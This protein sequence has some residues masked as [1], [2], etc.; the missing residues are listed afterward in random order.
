ML[1]TLE[2]GQVGLGFGG[3][4]GLQLFW[5]QADLLRQLSYG[6]GGLCSGDLDVTVGNI[7][8]QTLIR[9]VVHNVSHNVHVNK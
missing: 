9:E 8:K 5:K 1:K 7:K 2:E 6:L 4:V 3:A